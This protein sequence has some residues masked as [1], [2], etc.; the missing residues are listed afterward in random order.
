MALSPLPP[1]LFPYWHKLIAAHQQQRLPHALLIGGPQGMGKT[2]LAVHLAHAL[3]CE[4]PQPNGASCGQCRACHLLI[5]GNHPDLTRLERPENS[6]QILIDQVRKLIQFCALTASYGRYQVALIEP[7]EAMN[8]NS[9]NSLLK[10]LEEPPD[11]T[12]LM[13]VSHHP[14]KLLPTIRSRCQQLD[15]TRCNQDTIQQWLQ[16]QLGSTHN[17]DLLLSLTANAPLAALTLAQQEGLQHR[18]ALFNSLEALS[19]GQI[20]PIKV[21]SDWA[22]QSPLLLLQWLMSWVMDIIR[23][24]HTQRP[25]LLSNYDQK[26]IIQ[27]LAMR[28]D[29]VQTFA[30]LSLLEDSHRLLNSTVP[31]KANHLFEPITL[32]WINLSQ[33]KPAKRNMP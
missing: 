12:L 9:A 7:A 31:I 25:E 4:Q 15:L 14:M 16:T 26:A 32:G 18:Q 2:Q 28:L 23:F 27:R 21:A 8:I 24:A 11:N 3:L 5:I 29:I 13:L 19:S 1:W 22:K 17:I 10:L 6:Q 33:P 30:F 20:D